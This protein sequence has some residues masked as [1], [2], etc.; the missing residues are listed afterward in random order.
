MDLASI[1]DKNAIAKITKNK[2]LVFHA[3]GD[4]G[5]VNTPTY[6]EAVA[7]FME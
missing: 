3:V 1:L 4:T 2:K 6:I 5:G 7:R